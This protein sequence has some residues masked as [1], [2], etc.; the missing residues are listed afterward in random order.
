MKKFNNYGAT[1]KESAL[2]GGNPLKLRLISVEDNFK[3]ESSSFS[4]FFNM[5]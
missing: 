5:S 3:S 1:A 4:F 2:K